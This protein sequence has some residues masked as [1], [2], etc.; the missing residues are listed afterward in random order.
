MSCHGIPA[1]QRLI[2]H[3]TFIEIM[4]Q[5]AS[6]SSAVGPLR[7]SAA[8]S[9]TSCSRLYRMMSSQAAC[10]A[11]MWSDGNHL[12]AAFGVSDMP[13]YLSPGMFQPWVRQLSI[14][15]QVMI[16]MSGQAA[17]DLRNM[18][19]KKIKNKTLHSDCQQAVVRQIGLAAGHL[20]Q[21]QQL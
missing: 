1:L 12:Q 19:A 20:S 6:G 3:C 2:V 9:A 17:K 4:P 11:C 5:G 14:C 18:H 15:M 7:G 13:A 16:V 8:R 21:E 10:G